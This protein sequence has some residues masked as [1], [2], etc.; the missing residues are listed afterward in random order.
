MT[1]PLSKYSVD[2][3]SGKESWALLECLAQADGSDKENQEGAGEGYDETDAEEN[4]EEHGVNDA[5]A[6]ERP[7]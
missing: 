7:K 4:E 6:V 3:S 5:E 1:L 2:G